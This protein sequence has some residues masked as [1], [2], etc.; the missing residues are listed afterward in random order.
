MKLTQRGQ[1]KSVKKWKA[2]G[3]KTK[4]VVDQ[5]CCLGIVIS[6]TGWISK[7]QRKS[8]PKESPKQQNRECC[9]PGWIEPVHGR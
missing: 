2:D 4:D 1:I 5:F 6:K 3:S 9:R 8:T 7:I